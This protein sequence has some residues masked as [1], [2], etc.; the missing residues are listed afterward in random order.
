MAVAAGEGFVQATIAD[1]VHRVGP[2]FVDLVLLVHEGGGRQHDAVD[3]PHRVFQRFADGVFRLLI[4]F[5]DETAMHV[6][7]ADAQFQ[8][9][10]G[11]GGFRE[12]EGVFHRFDDA[13]QVRPR[14]EQP[15]LR[16]HG[17]GVGAFLHDRGALAIILTDDDHR[18]ASDAGR[19]EVGEGV[20][21]DVGAGG[22]F[23]GDGAANGVVDG[24]GEGGG[25]GGFAG[26]GFKMH[27][28][29]AENVLRVAQHVHQM[30]DRR[31]LV[32]GDVADAALQ[33]RLGDG[34]NAFAA[35][36]VACPEPEVLH[37]A[38]KRTFGHSI[39]PRCPSFRR[40][41][42]TLPAPIFQA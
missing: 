17:K 26:G 23:P 13:G 1:E 16:L 35:E 10:R 30:R 42:F 29:F 18:A 20:G 27:A 34:Q 4:V 25:G 7:G 31:A 41:I 2:A 3:V 19:G 6:A 28:E 14:V 5:G 38:G 12:F 21:G 15:H 22:G 8:H 37:F 9:D 40:S 11:V 24:G 33:Q 32:A 36:L 39:I